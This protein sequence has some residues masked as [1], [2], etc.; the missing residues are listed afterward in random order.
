MTSPNCRLFLVAPGEGDPIRLVDCLAAALAAGDVASLLIPADA[1]AVGIARMLTPAA[2]EGDVAVLIETDA[3]LARDLGA[4]G[5]EVSAG[6]AAYRDARATLGSEHIVGAECGRNRH[7]AMELAE[8]GADYVRFDAFSAGP[9]DECLGQWW[10]ELFE[11]PCVSGLP[12]DAE[13]V[14]RAAAIGIDFVRPAD[15]MWQSPEAAGK[16]ITQAT[17]AIAGAGQ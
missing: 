2:Q 8:A 10:A 9:G 11:V 12:L 15:A 4:D 13:D 1:G 5:V 3:G 16:V 14:A 7:L 6:L 17:R